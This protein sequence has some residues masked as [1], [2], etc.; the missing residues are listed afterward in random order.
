MRSYA[1]ALEKYGRNGDKILA[2]ISPAEARLLRYSGG[3]G[4]RNPVTGLLEFYRDPAERGYE[5]G[6][7]LGGRER[8]RQRND[9][10]FGGWN[11]GHAESIGQRREGHIGTGAKD[12][13]LGD[14][15]SRTGREREHWAGRAMRGLFNAVNPFGIGVGSPVTNPVTGRP[16]NPLDFN[17][18]GLAGTVM[19]IPGMG[20]LGRGMGATVDLGMSEGRPSGRPEDQRDGVVLLP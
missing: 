2:H 18:M 16:Q 3:A 7:P 20:L 15:G 11:A 8:D 19:G 12:R 6:G 9:P 14:W 10:A 17:P 5:G 4:T 13:S 1:K